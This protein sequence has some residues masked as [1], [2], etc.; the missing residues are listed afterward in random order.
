VKNRQA[1]NIFDV[2]FHHRMNPTVELEMRAKALATCE[3]RGAVP[4]KHWKEDAHAIALRKLA[5]GRK[6]GYSSNFGGIVSLLLATWERS[7]LRDVDK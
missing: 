1:G 3:I 4:P 5:I 7:R 2:P 6:V